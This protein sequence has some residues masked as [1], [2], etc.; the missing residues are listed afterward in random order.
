MRE[1]W[2]EQRYG[3]AKVVDS[4]TAAAGMVR[5]GDAALVARAIELYETHAQQCPL[6]RAQLSRLEEIEPGERG[7]DVVDVVVAQR[8][9]QPKAADRL[10]VSPTT[11]AG[12]LKGSRPAV[13]ATTHEGTTAGPQVTARSSAAS[14]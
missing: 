13:G 14:T 10:G 8:Y 12:D 3:L 4:G 2:T 1:A 11:I 9:S 6:I 5:A 7:R